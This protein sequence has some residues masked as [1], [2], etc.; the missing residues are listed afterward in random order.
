MPK[1]EVGA[2]SSV[3]P[4]D[5]VP[6]CGYHT[7]TSRPICPPIP[8]WAKFLERWNWAVN[9]QELLSLLHAGYSIPYGKTQW[10]EREYEPVDRHIFYLRM[11]DGWNDPW[12]LR[13]SDD[14][15]GSYALGYDDQGRA[16]RKTPVQLRLELAVKAFTMLCLNLFRNT[17]L[18]AERSRV[19]FYSD[20]AGMILTDKFLPVLMNFLRVTTDSLGRKEVC[21]LPRAGTTSHPEVHAVEFLLNFARFLWGWREEIIESWRDDNWK[22]EVTARNRETRARVNTAMLWM[23]EVLNQLD[24]LDILKEWTHSLNRPCLAKLKEIA[25]RA[26]LQYH[27]HPVDKDRRVVDLDEACFAGSK[28]AWFLQRHTLLTRVNQ[29]LVG[30]Q[31]ARRELEEARRRVNELSGE[32][33]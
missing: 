23:V 22:S 13:R 3:W 16:I 31:Q 32:K 5:A 4:V 14:G 28:A 25:L 2:G 19:E 29:R 15:D 17:S 20:W 30:E 1:S 33:K 18:Y 8:S 10:D 26:E 11:A 27:R 6:E 7:L 24:R 12:S 9:H 21:N